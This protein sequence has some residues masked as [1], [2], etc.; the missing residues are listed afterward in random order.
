SNFKFSIFFEFNAKDIENITKYIIQSTIFPPDL[1]NP[2]LFN[3]N[4]SIDTSIID[5]I[6]PKTIHKSPFSKSIKYMAK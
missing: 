2:S 5:P 3:V 6:K 1:E 4:I